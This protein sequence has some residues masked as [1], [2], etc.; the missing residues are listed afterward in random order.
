MKSQ[1]SDFEFNT[2]R[3]AGFRVCCALE[4][5]NNYTIITN[6]RYS[7]GFHKVML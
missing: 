7:G 4:M 6:R 5:L 3:A 1:Q 2:R